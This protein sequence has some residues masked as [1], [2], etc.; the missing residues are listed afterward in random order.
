[1]AVVGVASVKIKP[2]LST[3]RK[4]LNAE[5]KAIKAE[6]TVAVSVDTKKATAELDAWTKKESGEEI[7]KKI[8][9]DSNQLATATRAIDGFAA[10]G[11]KVAAVSLAFTAVTSAAQAL[12]PA[13][14]AASGAALL[15]P[16][17]AV[18]GV[19]VIATM[20]LG[21][22]GLKAAFKGVGDT[23]KANVSDVFKKEMVPAVA[24]LKTLISAVTPGFK[25]IASA[26]SDVT[27][28]I[29]AMAASAGK[30]SQI[31]SLLS[32]TADI[33]HNIGDALAPVISGFL[34]IAGV[35]MPI[36]SAI[37][38][39][40][41][42][43]AKK[44]EQWTASAA[45]AKQIQSIILGAFDAIKFI[46]QILVQVGAIFAAFFSGVSRG[47]G[48]LGAS[49]LPVLKAINTALSSAQG[50]A[51]LEALGKALSALGQ[52]AGGIVL[53]AF[54]ALAPLITSILGFVADHAQ[55]IVSL[56]LG[57]VVL[58]KA[59]AIAE[60]A[61][62][63]AEVVMWAFNAAADA[64]P[65]GLI[66]LAIGAL[67]AI[68]V[69]LIANWDSVASFFTGLWDKI[70]T[71][72]TIA[73]KWV[74]QRFS[75][76]WD[77]IKGVWNAVAG[78]F[79]GIWDGI[80]AGVS[81]FVD[82]VISFFKNIGTGIANGFTAAVDF[83]AALPGKILSFLLAL[84]GKIFTLFLQVAS[85]MLNAFVQGIEWILAAML[86]LPVK[87]VLLAIQAGKAIYNGVV[88]GVNFLIQWIPTAINAVI[89]FF[90]NLPGQLLA[91]LI[92]LGQ[93]LIGWITAAWNGVTSWIVTAF[94]NT[95]AFFV[96]LPQRLLDAVINF[97]AMIG[98]WMVDAWNNALNLGIT[99]VQNIIA[100]VQALPGRIISAVSSLATSLGTFFRNAWN[101]ALNA[102][103]SVAGDVF[104]FVGSI[105]GRILDALGN[106]GNM[107]VSVG[108][109]LVHGLWNGIS[110]AAEW[111]WGKIK[112]FASGIMDKFKSLLGI[113]SPSKLMRDEVGHWIPAGIAAGID[114]NASS[115]LDAATGLSDQMA[116]AFAQGAWGGADVNGSLTTSISG[117]GNL[118]DSMVTA[119]AT[120]LSQASLTIDPSGQSRIT[121]LGSSQNGRR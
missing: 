31:N 22:D 70:T 21:A 98:Q 81:F 63:A 25:E 91:A 36:L 58:S 107:L 84:P 44:F 72:V 117:P 80:T 56:A 55:L 101:G 62:A 65:I 39:G 118:F 71:G 119:V 4:E 24:S 89:T 35:G 51:V 29:T 14:V 16:A 78:F 3:F 45:G 11:V 79:T 93:L 85:F 114:G 2:D 12:G 32:Q 113:A 110:N 20:K 82:S 99:V 104:R 43:A 75:D 116:G 41:A 77:F 34:N 19:G 30:S 57:F 76:A 112:G 105:P 83:I 97:A 95:V 102:I 27:G 46:G 74:G 68:A 1:M 120:G 115:A 108:S 48:N 37:T 88:A 54:K 13:L 69:V 49:F 8:N 103:T 6:I 10:A 59:L 109:D 53:Q 92:G 15:I 86:A 94:D 38:Q 50:Q 9:V 23:L 73:A 60:A 67:I 26:I 28:K 52:A 33:V 66:V 47:A 87:L 42:G 5:L 17:A 64:N 90:V 106:F 7:K 61:M 40:L 121:S 111:L 100:W 96:A 18:A